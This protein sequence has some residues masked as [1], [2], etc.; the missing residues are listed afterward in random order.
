MAQSELSGKGRH[1][2]N[3]DQLQAAPEAMLYKLARGSA[4]TEVAPNEIAGRNPERLTDFRG[5][6]KMVR[7]LRR[8]QA[9]LEV[10]T[11]FRRRFDAPILSAETQWKRHCSARGAPCGHIPRVLY[12]AGA[13]IAPRTTTG[14]GE[15]EG[16]RVGYCRVQG[17]LGNTGCTILVR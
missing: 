6:Y 3:N 9:H 7:V 8:L 5:L 11:T 14:P 10:D 15:V 16:A 1:W 17:N 4:L 13:F 2:G 12:A